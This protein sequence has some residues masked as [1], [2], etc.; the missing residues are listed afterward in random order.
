VARIIEHSARRTWDSEKLSLHMG[1]LLDLLREAD[2]WAGQAGHDLITMADIQQALDAQLFRSSR[3]RER[4][5]EAIMEQT[6]MI[7]TDGRVVGQVN[8]LSVVMLDTYAF[9]RPSRITA[10]FRLGKGEVIDIER[11]VELGGPIHS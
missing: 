2:Y 5:Q 7:D 3:I 10:Q 9:G 1:S 6:I 4:V 11:Q 8:G